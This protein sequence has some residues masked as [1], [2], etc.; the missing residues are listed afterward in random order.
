MYRDWYI[1][2]F[3]NHRFT[4]QNFSYLSKR[5]NNLKK[6]DKKALKGQR[7]YAEKLVKSYDTA[8]KENYKTI[9]SEKYSQIHDKYKEVTNPLLRI[10]Y[11][12]FIRK[13]SHL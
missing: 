13:I 12:E 5:K 1:K 8:I 11:P 2:L 9:M 3:G 7:E 10:A 4:Q 6:L